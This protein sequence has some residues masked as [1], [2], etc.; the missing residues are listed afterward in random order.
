M[1]A[2]GLLL[3]LMGADVI[4]IGDEFYQERLAYVIRKLYQDCKGDIN[5]RRRVTFYADDMMPGSKHSVFY[6]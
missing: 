4:V 3:G 5:K 2:D 1:G 6:V